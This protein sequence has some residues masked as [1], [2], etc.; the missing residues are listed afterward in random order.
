MYSFIMIIPIVNMQIKLLYMS[1]H[2]GQINMYCLRDAICPFI[3]ENTIL[4]ISYYLK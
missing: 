3:K 4:K 1:Y 2:E